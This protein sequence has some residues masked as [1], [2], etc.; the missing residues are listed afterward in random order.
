[1]PTTF[2]DPVTGNVVQTTDVGQ[3]ITPVNNLES[4][5]SWWAGS[6]TSSGNAYAANIAPAPASTLTAGQVVTLTVN[7]TN[8]GPATLALNGTAAANITKSGSPL[9]AGDLVAGVSYILLYNGSTWSLIQ[10]STNPLPLT[11]GGT[12]AQAPAAALANL[13]GAPL[14]APGLTGNAT[15]ANLAISGGLSTAGII[16]T[17]GIRTPDSLTIYPGASGTTFTPGIYDLGI[18]HVYVVVYNVGYSVYEIGC[19]AGVNLA[20]F[21]PIFQVAVSTLPAPPLVN[22]STPPANSIG[23]YPTST[24]GS[25]T[26]VNTYA[27]GSGLY[28]GI[29]VVQV[30]GAGF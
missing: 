27:A 4:G 30:S 25:L 14:N 15:A 16:Y 7:V 13:G 17:Q 9:I 1:M 12:G 18:F 6:T 26:F 8:T 22:S 11:Q 24:S 23:V 10:G 3:F 2:N 5:H 19:W 29:S 28:A 20:G 21:R